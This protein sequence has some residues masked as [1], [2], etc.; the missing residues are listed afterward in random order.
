MV[1]LR[2]SAKQILAINGTAIWY[3]A[4]QFDRRAKRISLTHQIAVYDSI[5]KCDIIGSKDASIRE[6]ISSKLSD[7]FQQTN[8]QEVFCNGATSYKYYHQYHFQA[9]GIKGI[10][11]PSTSPANARYQMDDLLREWSVILN[12]VQE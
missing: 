8:I 10:K 7:I 12:Y 6:V 9:S 5:Y 3:P 11:L 1:F 2:S 4:I